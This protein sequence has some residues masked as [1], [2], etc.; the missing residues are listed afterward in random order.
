MK[1]APSHHAVAGKIGRKTSTIHDTG[2]ATEG[3]I[4]HRL[5]ELCLD[6]TVTPIS[7]Y[8]LADSVPYHAV[9]Q[10]TDSQDHRQN[11]DALLVQVVLL[12]NL[13]SVAHS[14]W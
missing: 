2:H 9:T 7:P 1:T 13:V 11:V 5:C 3:T 4:S 10:L 12:T 8:V 14:T 6:R